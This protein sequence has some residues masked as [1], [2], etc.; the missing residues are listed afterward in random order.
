MTLWKENILNTKEKI[1]YIMKEN[2]I[3]A[4]ENCVML[5]FEDDLIKQILI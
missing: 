4:Y 5:S 2:V 1:V 3:R